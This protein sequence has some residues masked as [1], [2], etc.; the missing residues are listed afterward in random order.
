MK[1]NPVAATYAAGP[2]DLPR[3]DPLLEA[4]DGLK[5]NAM[6]RRLAWSA[7]LGIFL[8]GYDLVIIGAVLL[9]LKPQ[10]HIDSVAMGFLGSAALAG[11]F[12]GALVGGYMCPSY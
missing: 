1:R 10:W 5:I 3:N 9:L 2:V 6:H 11:A 4:M 7:G 8:D 12:V